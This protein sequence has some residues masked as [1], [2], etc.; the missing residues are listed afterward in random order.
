MSCTVENRQAEDAGASE[1]TEPYDTPARSA[2]K[3]QHQQDGAVSPATT[4]GAF[5]SRVAEFMRSTQ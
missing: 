3:Q 1:S 2:F 4:G 5:W